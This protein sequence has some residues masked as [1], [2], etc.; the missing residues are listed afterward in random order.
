M[1]TGNR[2]AL[3]ISVKDY[4]NGKNRL[5]AIQDANRL[6]ESLTRLGFGCKLVLG[7]V[8]LYDVK[9]AIQDLLNDRRQKNRGT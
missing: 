9:R 4:D 7:W 1:G 3:I 6:R 2:D 8:A 5:N